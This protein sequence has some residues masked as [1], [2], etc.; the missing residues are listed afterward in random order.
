MILDEL[1]AYAVKR[2]K[3]AK[4]R[5][6]LSEIKRAAYEKPADEFPF[7]KALGKEGLSFICEIKKASPSKGII[8]SEFRYLEISKDY[9][10][11]GADCVSC[12]TEPKWFLGSEDIFRGIRKAISLPMLRKDFI[13]DEYQLYETKCMGA[14]TVLLICSLLDTAT[15]AKYLEICDSIGLS[16][17]VEAHNE[18]E[19]NSALSAKARIVGVNNRNLK[20]F[21]VDIK[22]AARLRGLVPS[23][24][25]FVAESGIKSP[26]DI[27]AMRDLGAD[28]VLIGEAIM[29]AADKKALLNCFREAAR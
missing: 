18:A 11:A 15:L 26:N 12:L 16:A 19:I 17:L 25:L 3:E 20:N 23:E 4:K 29:R 24:T 21:A 27:A 2:V 9:E 13:V 1:A 8:D 7:E 5:I 10:N 22:N 28:A 14:D 6:S